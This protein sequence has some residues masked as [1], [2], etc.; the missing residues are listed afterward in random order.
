MIYIVLHKP[1]WYPNMEYYVPIRVGFEKFVDDL[2]LTDSTGD[3][4]SLKNPYFSEL[5]ALYWIYRNISDEIVGLVHYRRYFIN[6]F[7]FN[8]TFYKL[9]FLSEKK[10]RRYF[11]SYDIIVP[12]P[13]NRIGTLY[14]EYKSSCNLE[15]LLVVKNIII[16][17][18]PSY[19]ESFEFVIETNQREFRFYYNMFIASRKVFNDYCEWLFKI[20]FEAEKRINFLTYDEYQRR[21]F[22]FLSERLFIVYLHHN[23][24]NYKKV[25]VINVE[26]PYADSSTLG[27][28]LIINILIK[29]RLYSL[30]KKFYLRLRG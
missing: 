2:M 15:D 25:R 7:Y 21:V 18:F 27:R 26:Y 16:E 6:H 22:G 17:L 24:L 9:N 12:E 30:V 20:L 29:V 8:R 23:R 28:K 11:S 5:T 10:I 19:N 14:D 1:S 4:I 13:L 3:N